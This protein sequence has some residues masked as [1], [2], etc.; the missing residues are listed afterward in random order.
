VSD[1]RPPLILSID[2]EDWNQIV[3]RDLGLPDWDRPHEAFERQV[4]NLLAFLD[5]LAVKATFFTLGM[6][7]RNY[8]DVVRQ[9]VAS[10]HELASHGFA[11]ARVHDQNRQE[12]MR[13]VEQSIEL[14]GDQANCRPVG[15][16]APAFSINRTCPWAYEVL[17]ELGFR[18]DSSQYDSPR[19]PRRIIGIPGEP[20]RLQLASGQTLIEFPVAVARVG[21]RIVPIGGGSYWRL[22][23]KRLLFRALRAAALPSAAP[24]LYFHPYEFDP[25]PLA[26]RLPVSASRRQRLGAGR[27]SVYWNVRRRKIAHLLREASREFRLLTY[28]QHL[29]STDDIGRARTK[30][31]S[32]QGI[33]V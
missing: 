33:L 23:P 4:T 12:F 15:Y 14:I 2:L 29:A 22:L 3:H 17:A 32:R 21:S 18:Y 5:E 8:P 28:E 25:Q 16:R 6:C 9:L 10:G 30:T 27:A 26:A 11:H 1:P 31:L 24:V 7:A 20:Y 13:D 19:V